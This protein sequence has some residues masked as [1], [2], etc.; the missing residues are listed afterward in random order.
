MT[1]RRALG[2]LIGVSTALRL[3]WAAC[4][5]GLTNEA[6]YFTYARHLSWGYYD[7]PPM[8]GAVA[9]AGLRLAGGVSSAFGLR[10]GFIL[11]F[12]GSTWLL[13]R[14]T[15]R[16]FGPRAG[17]FAALVLNATVYYGLVVGTLAA[18]D[19]PLL[20]FWLLTLDLLAVALEAPGRKGVWLAAGLA[21]GAA[22]MSKYYAVLIP[23]GV[24]LYLVLRPEAR[25]CLRAP[26]PYLATLAGLAVFSPVVYWNATHGWASFAFQGGRASGFD[27]LRPDMLAEALVAQALYL[28]P[29]V[30]VALLV[31][32]VRLARRGPRDWSAPE[33]FLACQALPALS[34]FL[35]VATFKRIMPH[36]PMIGFV[37][38]MSLLGLALS[39]LSAA[40]PVR[41]LRRLVLPVAFPVVLG[42]VFVVHAGTGLLQ[43][44]QGRLLGLIAPRADLTV[45]TVRWE[46]IARELGRRGLLDEPGTFLFTDH[47][48]F[49]AELE[50]ATGRKSPVA[51]FARDARSFTYWSR[52]TDWVG[53]DGVFV[54]VTD[55]IAGP[56]DYAPWFTRIEPL[57]AFPIVRGG[58]PLQTVHLYR[59][60]R[61]TDP[62]AFG[63]AGQGPIPVPRHG[64]ALG[65]EGDDKPLVIGHRPTP[66]AAR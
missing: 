11:M 4:L 27:G 44:G 59:C 34:L 37:P 9:A 40:D 29:W 10:L 22:M 47:W 61:Q 60:V 14:L 51:C 26:G 1:T 15:A 5:G 39:D 64:P 52:P 25:R 8:V 58:V 17:L 28:T 45:D 31:V 43:D 62:F 53:R 41:T 50:M 55:G 12:A 13:A 7:H 46:Q 38:L 33:A 18:P 48:K 42:S 3:I 19:G 23:S 16:W 20:F 2:A 32:L 54:R 24:L 57:G 6:Y 21:W 56:S 65:N 49:S 63:Y 35:G 36:W 66:R 30:F